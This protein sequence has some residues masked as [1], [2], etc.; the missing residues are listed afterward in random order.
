MIPFMHCAAV[1]R[2]RMSYRRR[3]PAPPVPT[4]HALNRDA[5]H[6]LWLHC[7]ACKRN[8]AT[9]LAPFVIRWGLDASS[10]VLRHNARCIVCGR[11]GALLTAVSHSCAELFYDPFPIERGFGRAGARA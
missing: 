1:A 2:S 8:V 4:L 11:R 3:S 7:P 5:P 6:W 10:D 9:P